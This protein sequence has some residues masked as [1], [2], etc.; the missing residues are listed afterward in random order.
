MRRED[1]LRGLDPLHGDACDLDA[2]LLL[3]R[4]AVNEASVFQALALAVQLA[5]RGTADLETADEGLELPTE[6]LLVLL[7]VGP[8]LGL[9]EGAHQAVQVLEQE[10]PV[11]LTVAQEVAPHRLVLGLEVV[12]DVDFLDHDLAVGGD[13]ALRGLECQYLVGVE[14]GLAGLAQVLHLREV[15]GLFHVGDLLHVTPGEEVPPEA[16]AHALPGVLLVQV[17]DVTGLVLRRSVAA[18]EGEGED[19]CDDDEDVAFHVVPPLLDHEGYVNFL[20]LV[21]GDGLDGVD[22][23]ER[24]EVGPLALGEARDELAVPGVHLGPFQRRLLL[25]LLRVCPCGPEDDLPLALEVGHD[26]LVEEGDVARP[27]CVALGIDAIGLVDVRVGEVQGHLGVDGKL[28]VLLGEAGVQYLLVGIAGDGGTH[29]AINV[30]L[31]LLLRVGLLDVP[32]GA[33][34][35]GLAELVDDVE[36]QVDVGVPGL[37]LRVLARVER[38][39]DDA[40]AVPDDLGGAADVGVLRALEEVHLAAPALGHGEMVLR[41]GCAAHE[42]DGCEKEEG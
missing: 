22:P 31:E 11:L 8:G 25:V 10:L 39:V 32:L 2:P 5:D 19:G 3:Q 27:H 26:G 42:K 6:G 16:G 41:N 13:D 18:E 29:D 12:G 23:V 34:C 35:L 21:L 24:V 9:Q 33:L 40:P 7:D 37:V 15:H 28:A 17:D 30:L 14:L 36:V 4:E 20:A 1:V 38:E